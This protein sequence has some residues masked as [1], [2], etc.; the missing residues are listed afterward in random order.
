MI[1][2]FDMQNK[3]HVV[4]TYSP[5]EKR[6]SGDEG[7]AS[8]GVKSQYHKYILDLSKTLDARFDTEKTKSTLLKMKYMLRNKA[9]HLRE[10]GDLYNKRFSFKMQGKQFYS[11]GHVA[12][13]KEDLERLKVAIKQGQIQLRNNGSDVIRGVFNH[14]NQSM[15]ADF[16]VR[17]I[18]L[19]HI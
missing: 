3:P 5:N 6:I 18:P 15:L 11:D 17:Y 16:G 2:L 19:S 10:F 8:T 14:Y 7:I 13:P 1:A 12:V 9:T 4:V